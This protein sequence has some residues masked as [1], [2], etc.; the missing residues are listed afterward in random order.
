MVAISTKG[1][2]EPRET[3][4]FILGQGNT[5]LVPNQEGVETTAMSV[6]SLIGDGRGA[7]GGWEEG[8]KQEV[9]KERENNGE[10]KCI[11][12]ER[13]AKKGRRREEKGRAREMGKQGAGSGK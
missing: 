7:E 1:L 2:E 11:G 9:L 5:E 10:R 3:L 4:H 8:G 6:R 13:K 12:S